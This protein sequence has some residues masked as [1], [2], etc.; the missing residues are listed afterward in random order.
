M[1][2]GKPEL[3]TLAALTE[4]SRRLLKS[5]RRLNLVEETKGKAVIYRVFPHVIQLFSV[6]NGLLATRSWNR[7]FIRLITEEVGNSCQPYT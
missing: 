1:K 5:I 6:S 7:Y 2:V 4:K 3:K